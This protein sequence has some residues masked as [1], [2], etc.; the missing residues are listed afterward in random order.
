VRI[1]ETERLILRTLT[2]ADVDDVARTFCDAENMRF[3]PRVFERCDVVTWIERNLK[4]YES[5]GIGM[6]AV[7]LKE[8]GHLIGDCGLALQQVDGIVETEIGYHFERAQ[9]GRG[10]ATE[11][12]RGCRDYGLQ[13]LHRKRL[14]S[15]I[16]AENTP[17]RR[18][19]ERNG[20][21][22]EKETV[23]ASLPH[24]VYTTSVLR[25]PRDH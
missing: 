19:A 17:S 14:I 22:V 2:L 7:I 1:L 16:R 12:A 11:A 13:V 4:R 15:L 21:V 3:F 9:Q 6:W 5:D 25:L 20:M 24:L 10:Y 8:T 23:F 18:V